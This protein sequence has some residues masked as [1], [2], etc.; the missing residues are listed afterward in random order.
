MQWP[1][2][3]SRLFH[4]LLGLSIPAGLANPPVLPAQTLVINEFL[5]SNQNVNVDEDGEPSDWIEIY[6]SSDEEIDLLGYTL[7]D[8]AEQRRQWVFPA[9]KL[10]PHAHLLIWASQKDRKDPKALHTNFK[11]GAGGEFLG[12][13]SP[14]GSAVDTLTFPA[15]SEDVAY[16]RF[17]DGDPSFFFLQIPTPG[18]VNQHSSGDEASLS[19]SKPEG[20]YSNSITVALVTN[21][22]GGEIR[23]TLTGD[24]PTTA[25]PLYAGPLALAKTVVLRGRVFVNGSPMSAIATRTYVINDLPRLPVLSV[26]TAPANLWDPNFG[27]YVNPLQEGRD[28]ERPAHLA[29]IE[30][31]MTKFALPMGLRIHGGSSRET[32]KKNFRVYFRNEY[33]AGT[34][35]HRVFAEKEIDRFESLVLHAPSGDQPTGSTKFTLIDDAIT[36][37]L[38]REIGGNISA[39]RPVSLYLNGEYWGIYWIREHV[40]DQYVMA[41]FGVTDMD[42]LRTGGDYNSA[43]LPEVR[44]GDAEFWR[45]TYAYFA[46]YYFGNSDTYELAKSKYINFEHFVDYNII[47]IMGANWDWPH[48]NHDR[49]SDRGG[50]RRWRWIMWDTGAAWN[51]AAPDHPTLEWATRDRVRIDIHGRDSEGKLWSTMMLRRLLENEE[52]RRYFINRFADLLNTLLAADNV[53]EHITRLSEWIRPEMPREMDR[54]GWHDYEQ[55][56]RNLQNVRSFVW[57]REGIQR[58]QIIDKFGLS[59]TAQITILPASGA[60]QITLN[61]IVLDSLPWQGTYFRDVPITLQATPAAGYTFLRWSDDSLP[62]SPII[63]VDVNRD[64]TVHA[65]FTAQATR[66][67]RLRVDS[68]AAREAWISW[69]TDQA[70]TSTV[71]YGMDTNYGHSQSDSALQMQ[72]LLHLSGLRENTLY[73][74]RAR[75]RNAAGLETLSTDS[76]FTTLGLSTGVFDNTASDLSVPDKFYL[77]PNYPNPFGGATSMYLHV[78]AAGRLLAVVYNIYGQEVARVFDGAVTAGYKT[79]RWDGV[80]ASG[81]RASNGVYFLRL[82]W[83]GIGGQHETAL[84]RLIMRE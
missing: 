14:S 54:W 2:R 62:A 32:E 11:L 78:P 46:S 9:M 80:S 37:S 61:T 60:G 18:Q 34:L 72:H 70:A 1:I 57:Q 31:G 15:Q 41:N 39:L 19:F 53:Q 26:V 21:A 16:G 12:L 8:K 63:T 7:T 75:S 68:V 59:G 6:N 82:V 3:T 45:E 5:A 64:F 49:F 22:A 51:H 10:E 67:S 17:P 71:D 77:S 44:A 13:F 29:L 47:N 69:E 38:W 4:F 33:G 35:R 20:I 52:G 79:L 55:W 65:I 84:A 73:H 66:L 24:E 76:T 28:W 50:D 43:E 42:L 81:L 83:D 25:S 56:D 36:H 23:Y 30:D 48:N 27:I 40:N 74:F 58:D